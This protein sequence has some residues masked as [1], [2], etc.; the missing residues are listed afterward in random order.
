MAEQAGNV[1]PSTK[2]IQTKTMRRS[3][4]G[5]DIAGGG[6]KPR[7]SPSARRRSSLGSTFGLK[8]PT[9]DSAVPKK[10]ASSS[11]ISTESL[12]D[13]ASSTPT[14]SPM[15]RARQRAIRKSVAEGLN[16]HELPKIDAPKQPSRQD[17]DKNLLATANDWKQKQQLV[18]PK[19]RTK[20]A[21]VKRVRVSRSKISEERRQALV[22]RAQR[23]NPADYGL[24]GVLKW[25]KKP[26]KSLTVRFEDVV[27]QGRRRSVC[28]G[29]DV[30]K[31]LTPKQPRRRSMGDVGSC[32]LPPPFV[33]EEQRNRKVVT[34]FRAAFMSSLMLKRIKLRKTQAATKIQSVVRCFLQKFHYRV[35]VLEHKLVETE[36]GRVK[37]LQDVED[38]KAR[39]M[40]EIRDEFEA[41]FRMEE[42][43]T[44]RA[45]EV[46]LYLRQENAKIAK[47]NKKMLM[48]MEEAKIMSQECTASTMVLFENYDSMEKAVKVLTN[49]NTKLARTC[50][51]YEARIEQ[52]QLE[53]KD[54][55]MRVNN[56]KKTRRN[57]EITLSE[58]VDAS[59]A[60][61]KDKLLHQE[62]HSIRQGLNEKLDNNIEYAMERSSRLLERDECSV[63]TDGT[64]LYNEEEAAFVVRTFEMLGCSFSYDDDDATFGN[65]T[66]DDDDKTFC[67]TSTFGSAWSS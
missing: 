15:H 4:S 64:S 32:V 28:A 36:K 27:R 52:I 24:K 48:H 21:F 11:K 47:Q 65:L 44:T 2:F 39:R 46:I 41:T 63:F 3:S 38:Y 59:K 57:M 20:K 14:L 25:T 35:M 60:G 10:R 40:V 18:S 50:M 26:S 61:C 67:T 12:I 34:L 62:I 55:D 45:K 43:M 56:E 8:A 29:A 6:S 30:E 13:S 33:A 51:K 37:D 1:R 9:F 58:V 53:L 16:K 66:F 49:R 42:E 17:S 54:V 5:N 23:Y 22:T 19:K 7:A 31:D